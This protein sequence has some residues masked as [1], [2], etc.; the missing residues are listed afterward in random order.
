MAAF[1]FGRLMLLATAA[2][3]FTPRGLMPTGARTRCCASSSRSVTMKDDTVTLDEICIP[4]HLSTQFEAQWSPPPLALG[5]CVLALCSSSHRCLASLVPRPVWRF[6]PPPTTV[7]PHIHSFWFAV[8]LVCQA[9]FAAPAKKSEHA[10]VSA[11]LCVG[12][13]QGPRAIWLGVPL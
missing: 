5:G 8:I 9:S 3:A 13:W 2:I 1:F 11:V 6:R 7:I 4:S 10:G 12:R